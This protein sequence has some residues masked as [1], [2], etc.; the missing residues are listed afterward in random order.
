MFI[1]YTVGKNVFTRPK[2]YT[3]TLETIFNMPQYETIS[4]PSTIFN[5]NN[6]QAYATAKTIGT[7]RS[8]ARYNNT[9]RRRLTKF[10]RFTIYR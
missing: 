8:R 3:H 2:L 10:V 1:K 7:I 5:A 4:Q 9:Y 6:E